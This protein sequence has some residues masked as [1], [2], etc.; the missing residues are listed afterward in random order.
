[1]N[2][3]VHFLYKLEISSEDIYKLLNLIFTAYSEPHRKYHG[4]SH[5]SYCLDMASSLKYNTEIDAGICSLALAYHD[6]VYNTCTLN[7]VKNSA[8][9]AYLH[10][11]SLRKDGAMTSIANE[12]HNLIMYTDYFGR[13]PDKV[14][15]L[16]NK[17]NN[18]NTIN[19]AQIV[20][21]IDLSILGTDEE[22]FNRY[23]A[24]IRKEYDTIDDYSYNS[25][26]ILALKQMLDFPQLF[27]TDT[28]Y[29]K[30]EKKA[31]ENIKKLIDKINLSKKIRLYL[32]Q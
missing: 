6:Y 5:L 18:T 1:M 25:A 27:F 29:E 3:L 22:Q 8:Y 20:C 12:V 9:T 23:E 31:R 15:K 26:R 32:L 16:K 30:Y 11:L 7:N 19:N 21:D 10:L 2:N 4:V 28:F 24:G 17:S 13:S 14:E